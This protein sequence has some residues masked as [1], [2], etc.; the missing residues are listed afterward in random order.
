MDKIC[1]FL[2]NLLFYFI[3]L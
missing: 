2:T 1:L 3:F